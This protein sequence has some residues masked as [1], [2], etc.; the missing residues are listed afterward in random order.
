MSNQDRIAYTKTGER[1]K[2]I[3]YWAKQLEH[4]SLSLHKL[5][6]NV[7]WLLDHITAVPKQKPKE[8]E[9][10][11]YTTREI[12]EGL[13]EVAKKMNNQDRFNTIGILYEVEA[14]RNRQNEKWGE[15][16]HRVVEWLSILGEEVGEANKHGL[17]AHFAK[18]HKMNRESELQNY[19]KEL[20]QI[21]A[22]AVAMAESVD[23]NELKGFKNVS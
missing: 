8:M 13:K 1:D 14:E 15:Q 12:I 9:K 23:R 2:K 6:E 16:N 11:T 22:V 3:L 5:V 4:K 18:I 7:K 17:Q 20:I 19:R 10:T 21:A